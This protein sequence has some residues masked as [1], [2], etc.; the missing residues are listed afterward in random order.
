MLVDDTVVV[1][2]MAVHDVRLELF[3]NL[4]VPHG[5]QAEFRPLAFRVVLHVTL[6]GGN[7]RMAG[8]VAD[9]QIRR[10]ERVDQ[11][12]QTLG[13]VDGT[14]DVLDADDDIVLLR[15][16]QK[17]FKAAADALPQD[18]DFVELA[19][20][21]IA[22]ANVD[23]AGADIQQ[24]ADLQRQLVAVQHQRTELFDRQVQIVPHAERR[25]RVIECQP[26]IRHVFTVNIDI[27]VLLDAVH[28][29]LAGQHKMLRADLREFHE[30]VAADFIRDVGP[31][32]H[33]RYRDHF[34]SPLV[35][36]Y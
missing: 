23:C 25:M 4:V 26:R 28:D 19:E 8:I 9:A 35:D 21:E 20:R 3:E 16:G 6:A 22:V 24:V 36:F 2:Q 34:L 11:R 15:D 31:F 18:V 32:K 27:R 10:L 1:M 33:M 14:P 17:L 5:L 29:H 30:Q 13:R 7:V 12:Q